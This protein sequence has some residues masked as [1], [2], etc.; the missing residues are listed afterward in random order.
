MKMMAQL[1]DAAWNSAHVMLGKRNR[2][3]K[4][5]N[6]EQLATL[7]LHI[8]PV[9]SMHLEVVYQLMTLE[10]AQRVRDLLATL[11]F[12]PAAKAKVPPKCFMAPLAHVNRMLEAGVGER[13]GTVDTVDLDQCN[14]LKYFT[15]VEEKVSGD[16]LRPITWPEMLLMLSTYISQHKLKTV[17]D[18]RL[19][20]LTGCAA[21]TED[22]QASF[23]QV[24]LG[25]K[26]NLVMIAE[27]GS[28]IRMKRMPYGA[29]AA[30]EIM[31]IIVSTLAGDPTYAK[32]VA[33]LDNGNFAR[34]NAVHID[35]VFF[36]GPDAAARHRHFKEQCRRARVQLNV[37][38]GNA[39]SHE[40]TFVGMRLDTRNGT[41]A[42]KPGYGE[43]IDLENLRT[44][45][46]LE[47]IMGKVLYAG[48][49]LAVRWRDYLFLLKQYRRILS[50][51]GRKVSGW[52]EPCK[53]WPSARQQL[54][55]LVQ[56]IREN[57]PVQVLDSVK[58]TALDEP[59]AVVATDAT[60][61]TF[62]GVLLRPGHL[63]LA[64]GATF[65]FEVPD[66][67]FA[68]ATA[69]L[70]MLARFCE[71][72][73]GKKVLV[74]IDNTSALEGLKRCSSGRLSAWANSPEFAH[75]NSE[76]GIRLRFQYINT[77]LN[78]ADAPS[79]LLPLDMDLVRNVMESAWGHRE[80]RIE[81]RARGWQAA[82]AVR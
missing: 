65:P 77:K 78:P 41:V 22:L 62:G 67:N 43:K 33:G 15:V 48:A 61:K 40:Q 44:N 55:N 37:E 56:V 46:D 7:P 71:E 42:L 81:R 50:K 19:L 64:F 29:D 23:H 11:D 32:P 51:C 18:Y 3:S 5:P 34:Y 31:H 80:A 49:V 36:G 53:L 25:P 72:L 68:E 79:R 69:A 21:A 70:C 76:Y 20:A 63:P 9:E 38:P 60:L 12:N 57:K 28:V 27:D 58:M 6:T 4:L 26:S 16:R 17:F 1:D 75:L 54:E 47:R 66:I 10:A 59:D 35:N 14:L 13:I 74:L 82:T 73:R 8:K 30:S 39:F 2:R 24:E 45:E 52:T